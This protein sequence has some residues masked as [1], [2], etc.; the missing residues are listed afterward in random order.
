MD[1]VPEVTGETESPGPNQ[2]LSYILY[3]LWWMAGCIVGLPLIL[4]WKLEAR[5]QAFRFLTYILVATYLLVPLTAGVHIGRQWARQD[6]AKRQEWQPVTTK[7][8]AIK[9]DPDDKR[10]GA[11]IWFD[12]RLPGGEELVTYTQPA[13]EGSYVGERKTVW[14]SAKTARIYAEDPRK[15]W[16]NSSP[17]LPI[18]FGSIGFFIGVGLLKWIT[19]A[20]D[21]AVRARAANRALRVQ[22]QSPQPS[23]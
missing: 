23:P 15:N 14:V 8:T 10:A 18:W 20:Y 19:W 21:Q 1:E 12:V 17:F 16:P 22:R 6:T 7:I 4:S 13:A 3:L 9:V 5:Q 2:T 11:L